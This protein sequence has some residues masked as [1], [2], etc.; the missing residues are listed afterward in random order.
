MRFLYVLPMYPFNC[1]ATQ[2][3]L[4]MVNPLWLPTLL[5][6]IPNLAVSTMHSFS[7]GLTL[8]VMIQTLTSAFVILFNLYLQ[9]P[10]VNTATNVR[11]MTP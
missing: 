2:R 11:V 6:C 3:E 1:P 8:F 4:D 9:S 5:E 10:V 7:K